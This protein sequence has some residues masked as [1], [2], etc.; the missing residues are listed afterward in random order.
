M[1][2]KRKTNSVWHLV[3][4][5]FEILWFNVKNRKTS[6]F[7]KH[8]ILS[9]CAD[10]LKTVSELYN[11]KILLNKKRKIRVQKKRIEKKRKTAHISQVFKILN[12]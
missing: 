8:Y 5:N 12:T 1:I 3:Y 7:V 10:N 6:V 11:V 4:L 9:S 2:I